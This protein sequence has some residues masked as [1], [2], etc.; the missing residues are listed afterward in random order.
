ML[1]LFQCKATEFSKNSFLAEPEPHEPRQP[2]NSAFA[3]PV[4]PSE[5]RLYSQ[6][7]GAALENCANCGRTI[8]HLETP[9]IWREVVVCA[10][11]HKRLSAATPPPLKQVTVIPVV[12]LLLTIGVATFLVVHFLV[13]KTAATDVANANHAFGYFPSPTG[14]D[15][16]AGNTRN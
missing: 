10:E 5:V 2:W 3:S 16:D 8:G 9:N 14:T 7:Q 13:H 1:S 11:C 4:W 6:L 15:N 12:F